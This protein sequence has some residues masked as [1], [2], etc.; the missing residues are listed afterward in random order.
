M[1]DVKIEVKSFEELVKVLEDIKPGEILTITALNNSE[2]K[3]GED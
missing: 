2:E 1:E 3:D